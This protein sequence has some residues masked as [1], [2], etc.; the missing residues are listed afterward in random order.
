MLDQAIRWSDQRW[1][2]WF[3][4]ETPSRHDIVV[5][6]SRRPGQ[7]LIFR[8]SDRAARPRAVLKLGSGTSA[9]AELV[10]EFRNLG[11]V[12]DLLPPH[13]R[14][15]VPEPLSV[16]SLPKLTVLAMTVIPGRRLR[17]ASPA[18][19]RSP[20]AVRRLR[21][22]VSSVGEW[23]RILAGYG[24]ARD[25]HTTRTGL[26]EFMRLP[27]DEVFEA[28]D[29]DK[30]ASFTSA[31]A[32]SGIM[33]P[34]TWQHGD[35]AVGNLLQTRRGIAVVDWAT[36]SSR[37]P[38]WFDQCYLM[39]TLA[40]SVGDRQQLGAAGALS[41]VLGVDTWCGRTLADTIGRGWRFEA[42]LGWALLMTSIEQ[43]KRAVVSSFPPPD[44]YVAVASALMSD[45]QLRERA[46]WAV[47]SW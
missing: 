30:L 45:D 5:N 20:R 22:Y 11:D 15:L 26:S 25:A 21:R 13:H 37:F 16:L 3:P 14:H 24:A 28:P 39:L 42:P 18:A 47:P 9:G 17:L 46:A 10:R 43:V 40:K 29:R 41:R 1:S 6:W 38:P 34:P 36:A 32:A 8:Q 4:G 35:V 12:R 2:I 33:T 31:A 27:T 44:W 7:M 19:S 23:S